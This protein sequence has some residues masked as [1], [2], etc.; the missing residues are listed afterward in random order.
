M[1]NTRRTF[2]LKRVNSGEINF[3]SYD[4]YEQ[5]KLRLEVD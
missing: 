1:P 5:Q 3:Y 4:C 2:T